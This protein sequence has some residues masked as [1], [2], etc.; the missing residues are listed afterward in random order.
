M[1]IQS[2]FI[3]LINFNKINIEEI[4]AS[5]KDI[6]KKLNVV[7]YNENNEHSHYEL[8]GSIGR[9][10]AI[11]S[12]D[13]DFCYILPNEVFQR[14]ENRKGNIQSYLICEIKECLQK[15]YPNSEIKGDGQVVDAFFKKR[16]VELVPSFDINGNK[17][18]KYP[19]THNDGSWCLTSPSNQKNVINSFCNEFLFY[20]EACQIIRCWK[21]EQNV[22]IKGI[23]IDMLAVDFFKRY[24]LNYEN[25][26]ISDI[27]ILSFLKEFFNYLVNDAPQLIPIIG[28]NTTIY[29]NNALFKKKAKKALRKLDETNVSTLW[30]NCHTLFGE[31]FPNNPFVSV[32]NNN[33]Q[34]IHQLFPI[35]ICGS[36]KINCIISKKGYRTQKLSELLS[37]EN[38]NSEFVV[39]TSRNLQFYIEE[40]DIVRPYDIYW[41]VKNVG[42][43]AIKMD[44]IRGEIKK[45]NENLYERSEFHGPHYVECYIIKDGKCVA[46]DRIDVPII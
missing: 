23:E 13:V 7:Y 10:T 18:L 34:F 22:K 16:L 25:K 39:S 24:S 5:L 38:S 32:K 44:N 29:L 31:G 36:L 17:F 41:K 37:Q 19:D 28:D 14:F 1:N 21:Q 40:C 46:K 27:D 6:I 4:L 26:K 11:S 2:A 15:R 33:E 35:K 43:A 12:S 9:G 3:E 45:G 20:K 42:P 8:T 30:D